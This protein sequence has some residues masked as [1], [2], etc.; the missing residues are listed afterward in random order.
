MC[1]YFSRRMQG[2]SFWGEWGK[3]VTYIII[4]DLINFLIE[5]FSRMEV[6]ILPPP[7]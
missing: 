2:R 1:I 7:A 6:F 4:I 5:L 3:G